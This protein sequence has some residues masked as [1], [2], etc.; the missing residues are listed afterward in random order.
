M[1]KL[2]LGLTLLASMSAF[3]DEIKTINLSNG[4]IANIEVSCGELSKGYF[5]LNKD[6]QL[7]AKCLPVTCSIYHQE[8]QGI[9]G[10]A[11]KEKVL[12]I[13]RKFHSCHNDVESAKR[14][15]DALKGI[16]CKEV[17]IEL[18]SIGNPC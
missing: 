15:A 14:E 5:K 10:K 3:A 8:Y 2:L 16:E 13:D 12:Y 17:K 4:D 1:K 7:T 18:M 11:S 6:R 9:R